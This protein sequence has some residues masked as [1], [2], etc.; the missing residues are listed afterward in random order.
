MDHEFLI[1]LPYTNYK[2]EIP[3]KHNFLQGQLLFETDSRVYAPLKPS[4]QEK[5]FIYPSYLHNF[6]FLLFPLK[7]ILHTSFRYSL[8]WMALKP[9][10]G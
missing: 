4:K 1:F 10:I 5:I 7:P 8:P 6:N 2:A 3:L 9:R